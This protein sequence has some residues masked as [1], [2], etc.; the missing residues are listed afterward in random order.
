[1]KSIAYIALVSLLVLK[2]IFMSCF[3]F[4]TESNNLFFAKNAIASENKNVSDA[5]KAS[6]IIAEENKQDNLP[7]I[8]KQKA[9][10]KARQEELKLQQEELAAVKDDI[11]KKIEQLTRLREEIK[12]DFA[13]KDTIDAQKIKHLIKAYS[14]MKPQTAAELIEKLDN[15]FA[16]ELLSQMKGEA[17]GTILSYIDKDKAAKITVS[18][19]GK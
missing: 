18:L 3:V 8:L 14:T 5:I 19:A 1:M 9:E 17:V 7:F 11:N 2:I 10:L 4:K 16:V 6:P 12:L 15:D 13:K